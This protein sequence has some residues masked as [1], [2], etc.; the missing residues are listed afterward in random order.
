M[1]NSFWGL[2]LACAVGVQAADRSFT[3]FCAGCGIWGA[4]TFVSHSKQFV[5]HGSIAPKLRLWDG[6]TNSL[7]LI[8]LEP[9]IFA[10]TA[11]R[12]KRAFLQELRIDDVFR[13][14][15]HAVIMDRLPADR[16][17]QLVSEVYL[18]G[19]EYRIGVPGKMEHTRLI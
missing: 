6:N 10:I 17:V 5:V 4:D 8:N 16:P 15:I 14:K 12:T 2:L 1:R 13:D 18:D 11:E 7:R 19:F 3:A 9:Q